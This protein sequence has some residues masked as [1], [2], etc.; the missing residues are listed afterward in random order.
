MNKQIFPQLDGNTSLGDFGGYIK[1]LT[2][3]LDVTVKMQTEA[4]E[5]GNVEQEALKKLEAEELHAFIARLSFVPLVGNKMI[6]LPTLAKESRMIAIN[7]TTIVED[8]EEAIEIKKECKVHGQSEVITAKLNSPKQKVKLKQYKER[9][10]DVVQQ[11]LMDGINLFSIDKE[12]LA[13]LKSRRITDINSITPEEDLTLFAADIRET[14]CGLLGSGG[15]NEAVTFLREY[16]FRPDPALSKEEREE[17]M[18]SVTDA[19]MLLEALKDQYGIKEPSKRPLYPSDT[20]EIPTNT[21]LHIT[22]RNKK[23]VEDTDYVYVRMG[24]KPGSRK[25]IKVGRNSIVC[26]IRDVISYRKVNKYEERTTIKE[27]KK[28]YKMVI[29]AQERNEEAPF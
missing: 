1:G 27:L 4:R 17:K 12:N 25:V 5:S 13:E 7:A 23:D 22:Y 9:V 18:Y 28:A 14:L 15:R 21:Y 26:D 24:D 6:A 2:S 29:S 10:A 3:L 11:S 19:H 20:R 16:V 8:V